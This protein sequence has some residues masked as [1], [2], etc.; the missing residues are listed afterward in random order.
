M[1]EARRKAPFEVRKARAIEREAIDLAKRE[2]VYRQNAAD[3]PTSTHNALMNTFMAAALAV[4]GSGIRLNNT[5]K[6]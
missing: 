6:V 1:G 5:N 3:R 2:E 4:A